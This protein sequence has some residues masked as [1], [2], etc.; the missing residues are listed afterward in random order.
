M[1]S[2][3]CPFIEEHTQISRPTMNASG[4]RPNQQFFLHFF[5]RICLGYFLS[6]EKSILELQQVVPYL[7][8]QVES[9]LLVFH[10]IPE[11]QK[12]FI[13]LIEQT[14][15]SNLI[16]G[17]GVQL[18]FFFLELPLI[19]VSLFRGIFYFDPMTWGFYKIQ[20]NLMCVVIRT[21]PTI[22]R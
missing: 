16:D 4:R 14:F 10:L 5:H 3:K 19:R 21:W 13:E 2:S 1:V 11:K 20:P 9:I 8:F 15:T 22:E 17:F 7:G 6:L 12:K 18:P